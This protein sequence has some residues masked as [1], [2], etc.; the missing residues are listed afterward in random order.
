MSFVGS[1]FVAIAESINCC[2]L[3]V[4]SGLVSP[5]TVVPFSIAS[6]AF[7]KAGSNDP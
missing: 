4:K 1:N 6:N 3:V 2:P 7:V 5:A